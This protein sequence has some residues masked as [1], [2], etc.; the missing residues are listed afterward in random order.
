MEK[1]TK[2]G[3]TIAIIVVSLAAIGGV[4]VLMDSGGDDGPE[5]TSEGFTAGEVAE[6][7]IVAMSNVGSYTYVTEME[8]EDQYVDIRNN[9]TIATDDVIISSNATVTHNGDLYRSDYVRTENGDVTER[10]YY[11]DG[12]QNYTRIGDNWNLD[13]DAP[14]RYY[15][16]IYAEFEWE[17]ASIDETDSDVTLTITEHDVDPDSVSDMLFDVDQ[18]SVS[19]DTEIVSQDIE[20][21]VTFDSEDRHVESL[22]IEMTYERENDA[23]TQSTV[24]R[25]MIVEIEYDEHGSTTVSSPTLFV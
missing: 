5:T 6:R 17:N 20:V 1:K 7:G 22:T 16:A 13:E 23:T 25:E 21:S 10:G 9:E 24:E 8:T 12:T 14:D 15:T 11:T 18:D 2:I 3:V 19:G 4:V